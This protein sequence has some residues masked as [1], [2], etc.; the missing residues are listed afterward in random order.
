MTCLTAASMLYAI[1]VSEHATT[2]ICAGKCRHTSRLD[3]GMLALIDR[4]AK[5]IAW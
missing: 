2:H 1:G 4:F 5:Q 3:A